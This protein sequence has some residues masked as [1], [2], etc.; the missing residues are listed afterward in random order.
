MQLFHTS[1][2]AIANIDKFGRFGTFLCFAQDEYVMTAGDHVSY[3]LNIEESAI[4]E[5]DQLFYHEDAEKLQGLVEQVM[6]MLDCDEDTAEDMLSQKDDCGDA[7]MSWDI[8]RMTAEAAKLLGF[9]GVSMQDEQGTCYMIDML[10][11]ES[12]LVAA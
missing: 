7:E 10:G 11:R 8:Q 6:G 1:P 2:D 3:T 9:R 4:I 12:E 5:A